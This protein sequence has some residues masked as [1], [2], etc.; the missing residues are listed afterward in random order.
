MKATYSFD[1]IAHFRLL[2]E[3]RDVLPDLLQEFYDSGTLSD[4]LE[5]RKPK[6]VDREAVRKACN[7]PPLTPPLLE[8]LGTIDVPAVADPLVVRD[9]FR[10]GKNGISF[11][12]QNFQQWFWPKVEAPGASATLRYARLTRED[13]DEPIRKEIGAAHEET[14]LGQILALIR[15]QKNGKRGVLFTDGIANIFYV[16][17]ADETLRAVLVSWGGDGWG[18]RAVSVS[19]PVGW[20]VGSRVFSRNS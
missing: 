1:Q 11:V 4:L 19:Y 5:V 15:R 3:Q 17:D 10:V 13:L 7:L 14:T 9:E 16:R 20:S 18:V 12:G 2:L 8:V 6:E